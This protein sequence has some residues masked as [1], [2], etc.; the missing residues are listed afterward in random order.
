MGILRSVIETFVLTVLDAGHDL[1]LGGR[2]ASQLI[3]DQHTRRAA[4]LL[5]QLAEQAFGGLLIAPALDEDIENEAFLIDG[6]PEPVLLA[7]DGDDD[8]IEVPLVAAAR[9]SPT[10]AVGKFP[11]EFQAPLPDRLVCDRDAAS[12]QHRFDHAQAQR[13]PEIEPDRVADELGGMAIARINR[14]SG[15]GHRTQIPD[16]AHPRQAGR[17]RF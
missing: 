7:G 1:S 16:Q 2:V 8:L 15:V 17:Q 9:G 11:S 5:K 3:G 12:C 6:A 4:L 10:D 14:I 13:E